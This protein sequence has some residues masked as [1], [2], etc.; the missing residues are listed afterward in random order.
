MKGHKKIQQTRAA[1]NTGENTRPE[2]GKIGIKYSPLERGG[3]MD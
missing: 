3:K 2:T 1:E